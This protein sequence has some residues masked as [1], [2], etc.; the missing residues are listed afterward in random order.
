MHTMTHTGNGKKK[1]H[2]AVLA[3]ALGMPRDFAIPFSFESA[4]ANSVDLIRHLLRGRD[5]QWEN[6]ALS[7]CL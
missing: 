6:T 2:R 1:F 4:G 5:L 3:L 7:L